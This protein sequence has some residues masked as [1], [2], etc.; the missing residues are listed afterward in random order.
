MAEDQKQGAASRG[1]RRA[2]L[3]QHEQARIERAND[4]LVRVCI[5]A[6]G[7]AMSSLRQ[8]C[9]FGKFRCSY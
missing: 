7:I 1:G 4:T 6:F 8:L 9:G 2:G 3:G 5:I